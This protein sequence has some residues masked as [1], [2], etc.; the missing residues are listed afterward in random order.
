MA[1]EPPNSNVH[2]TKN[3]SS[4]PKT[5][6]F[7]PI[8]PPPSQAIGPTT[9]ISYIYSTPPSLSLAASADLAH[10]HATASSGPPF[11]F[12]PPAGGSAAGYLDFA[13]N[14]DQE[15]GAMHRTQTVDYVVVVDGVVELGLDGGGKR[16][17]RKGDVV[18]QRGP[19]HRWKNLSRT[20]GARV[21]VVA[22]G[23]EGAVEGGMEF[24]GVEGGI[25]GLSGEAEDV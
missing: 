10:H 1:T 5:S 12:F 11:L 23:A 20:E 24:G 9:S 19:M 16:V 3:S 8:T 2:I 17:V 14:P 22:L 18:V 21:V 13:P 4:D 15:E 25:G 6:S 7:L